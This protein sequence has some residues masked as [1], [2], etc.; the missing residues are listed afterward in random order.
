LSSRAEPAAWRLEVV[1][2]WAFAVRNLQ[3]ASRNVF[4]LFELLFWPVLGVAQIGLMGRFLTL[5]PEEALF[6][7]IGQ[8]AFSIV[9]TCQLDVAYSVLYDYWSK[10][11]KHQ[12]LAPIAIRHLTIGS[13][14]VGILRGL[15]V[16]VMTAALA[17]WA[18][19]LNPLAAGIVPVL[20][21]LIGC[22]LTAWIV[23]IFV[24]SLLMLFG[25]RA[26]TSA[27]A[28]INL[29]LALAGIYYPLSTMPGWAASL[30]AAIPLTYFLEAYR[31]HF[32]F[33][34]EH[35]A[36]LTTGFALAIG[37]IALAHLTLGSAVNHA[38]RT[39]LLLKMSE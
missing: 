37:Y 34:S 30:G 22:F 9:G 27:W 12:F 39:G 29:V 15:L 36:P 8:M 16:F 17:W 3:M 33:A 13:W 11:M 2:A 18:F 28:S 23:G 24:C 21:L 32:G 10:S 1:A 14:I 6:I 4:L 26:E 20:L 31:A 19:R 5:R 35:A 7:L 25:G 38:R